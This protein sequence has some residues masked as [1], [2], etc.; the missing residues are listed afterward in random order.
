VWFEGG[1]Y[2]LNYPRHG[3]KEKLKV[4][5]TFLCELWSGTEMINNKI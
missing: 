4:I 1:G 5:G 2:I 3:A